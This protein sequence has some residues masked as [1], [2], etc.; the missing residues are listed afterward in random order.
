MRVMEER[1]NL[2]EIAIKNAQFSLN[3][4]G[5]TVD[6]ACIALCKKLLNREISFDEYLKEVRR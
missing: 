2:S 3:M 5:Y 6:E 4:E 1:V